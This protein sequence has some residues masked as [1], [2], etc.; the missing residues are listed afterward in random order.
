MRDDVFDLN[1]NCFKT[2]I[3]LLFITMRN[4]LLVVMSVSAVIISSSVPCFAVYD[5]V[6][7]STYLTVFTSEVQVAS[8]EKPNYVRYVANKLMQKELQNSTLLKKAALRKAAP[9][10]KSFFS[11]I[12]SF[13]GF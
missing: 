12:A 6:A 7:E 3:Y 4:F 9:R 11:R 13:F 10:K 2:F 1:L 8:S 5:P